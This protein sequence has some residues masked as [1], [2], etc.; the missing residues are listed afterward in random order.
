MPCA[1]PSVALH[2]HPPR[3]ADTVVLKP[4][5]L[6]GYQKSM[7]NCTRCHSA[8]YMQYQPPTA[9]RNCWDA[10]VHR[11]KTVFKAPVDDAEMADIV[12]Y[13]AKTYSSDQPK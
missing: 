10:M 2:P 7:A 9:P 4:S 11:M 6:P 13:L 3:R 5:P 8:Q 1:Q 12:D